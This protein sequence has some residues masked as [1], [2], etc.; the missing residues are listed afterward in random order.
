[1][2]NELINLIYFNILIILIFTNLTFQNKK[3]LTQKLFEM[4]DTNLDGLLSFNEFIF[5]G[6]L[7]KI[8]PIERL[9]FIKKLFNESDFDNNGEL[10]SQELTEFFIILQKQWVEH[11]GTEN[12][13]YS[14]L[15]NINKYLT[16]YIHS[17][18]ENNF[19]KKELSNKYTVDLIEELEG[20]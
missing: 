6:N 18:E 3:E 19:S 5:E 4:L 14:I 20:I 16:K 9:E 1:M 13:D 2:S 7:E 17:I 11:G 12:I 8:E 10:N 15:Q